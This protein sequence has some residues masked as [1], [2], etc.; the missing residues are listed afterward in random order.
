MAF[1][2]TDTMTVNQVL[3]NKPDDMHLHLR[4][5]LILNSIISYS[6]AYFG[7]AV[8]MPNLLPPITTSTMLRSYRDR[9][10]MAVPQGHTFKPLMTLYLTDT[11]KKEEIK[12][13]FQE[14]LLSA[15]KLYPAGATTNSASGVTD[16]ENIFPILET[17]VELDV[18]LLIHGEVVDPDIDIFDREKVFIERILTP[19]RNRFPDLRIVLEHITTAEGVNFVREVPSNLFA[20]ITPH[21]LVLNRSDIFQNGI[22]PHNFCLPILKREQHRLALVKAATSGDC[23]FFLGTDSAPHTLEMKEN[24]CGCAGIFNAPNALGV[25]AS[26]FDG[27]EAMEKLAMFT[28]IS[29]S[30]FY[31][32]DVNQEKILLVKESFPTTVPEFVNIADRKIKVFD[33]G[34][35]VFWHVR[36]PKSNQC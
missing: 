25:L 1:T 12:R 21:H 20:T 5:G 9:I 27:E 28:S 36:E 17:M 19:L 18:P 4:D 34:F 13:A 29:G 22:N 7:R 35:D 2:L 30:N 31:K 3:I 26:V 32:L 16:I 15:V 14:E 23:R 8:I 10:L 6:S 11:I 33:P 24:S